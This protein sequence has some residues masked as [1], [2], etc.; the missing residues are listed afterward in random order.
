M[1]HQEGELRPKGSL[2]SHCDVEEKATPGMK[3]PCE[4]KHLKEIDG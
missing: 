3:F 4:C 2:V 1:R